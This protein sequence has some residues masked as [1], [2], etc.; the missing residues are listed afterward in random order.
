MRTITVFL[1]AGIL[2]CTISSCSVTGTA[3]SENSGTLEATKVV[4][5]SKDNKFL[6][7]A[8]T[9]PIN[10]MEVNG[11]GVNLGIPVNVTGYG[12]RMGN[13]ELSLNYPLTVWDWNWDSFSNDDPVTNDVNRF[14]G[15]FIYGYPVFSFFSSKRDVSVKFGEFDD[16]NYYGIIPSQYLNSVNLRIGA[17]KDFARNGTL[18]HFDYLNE[19]YGTTSIWPQD[20]ILVRQSSVAISLGA[21]YQQFIDLVLEGDGD[22]KQFQGRKTEFLNLYFDVNYLLTSSMDEVFLE[23]YASESFNNGPYDMREILPLRRLGFSF[24][25][26]MLSFQKRDGSFNV[27]QSFEFGTRSGYFASF[28][29]AWYLRYAIRYGLGWRQKR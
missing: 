3:M 1:T 4:E 15:K 22:G 20:E 10:A 16:K 29:D 27:T 11:G 26:D 5:V 7:T 8:A 28:K 25:I 19:E 21:S 2:G 17:L 24:G 13:V 9:L 23:Y 18:Y 12:G 14:Q 6:S